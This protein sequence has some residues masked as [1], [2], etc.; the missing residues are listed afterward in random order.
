MLF[1]TLKSLSQQNGGQ[2]SDEQSFESPISSS[3]NG[4]SMPFGSPSS[5]MSSS[6]KGNTNSSTKSSSAFFS[7]PFYSE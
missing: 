2:F 5:T 6:Y 7:R 4:H 3:F 1:E